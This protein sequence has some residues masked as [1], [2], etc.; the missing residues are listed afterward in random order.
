MCACLGGSDICIHT[1]IDAYIYTYRPEV[2]CIAHVELTQARSNKQLL[3]HIY[4]YM[5]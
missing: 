5:F 4:M 2:S 3:V 1:Y